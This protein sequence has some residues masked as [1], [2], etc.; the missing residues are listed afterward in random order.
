MDD[1]LDKRAVCRLLGGSKPIDQSTLW[2]WVKAGLLPKP[3]HI[4]PQVRRWSRQDCE[5]A[6][7][8][9]VEGRR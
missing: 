3:I 8:S 7:R 1:L 5:A 6:L 2:R 4:G 9:M